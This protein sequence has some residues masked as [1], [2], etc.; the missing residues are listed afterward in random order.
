MP[1]PGQSFFSILWNLFTEPV[2]QGLVPGIITELGKDPRPENVEDESVASFLERRL[3]T[4]H[5]GNHLVSAVLHGIYAGDVNQLSARSLMP[6]QYHQERA[7]GS[8]AQSTI[9]TWR[10]GGLQMM[11]IQDANLRKELQDKLDLSL[12]QSIGNASIYTF[13]DGIG[14]LTNALEKS[15]RANPNIEIKIQEKIT[16]VEHDSEKDGIKVCPHL[17]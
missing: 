15:L 11:H 17:V 13:K 1:G 12:R 8:I 7:A 16:S 10:T 4:P 14:A 3:G 9:N 5:V 2:F 6:M